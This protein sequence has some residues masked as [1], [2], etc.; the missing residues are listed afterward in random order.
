MDINFLNSAQMNAAA[1]GA[2]RAGEA[3]TQ[4][5]TESE[6]R[7]AAEEFEAIFIAQMLAPMFNTIPKNDVFGGGHAETIFQSMQIEEIGKEITRAGGG[8]IGIA[9]RVFR[10]ILRAQESLDL[11]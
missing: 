2:T 6:A 1:A 5:R 3:T 11:A 9:D 8:G 7:K 4:A 10:E